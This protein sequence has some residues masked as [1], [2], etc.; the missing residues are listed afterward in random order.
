MIGITTFSDQRFFGIFFAVAAFLVAC[1]SRSASAGS[2][3]ATT[4]PT[5]IRALIADIGE[6]QHERAIQRI[7]RVGQMTVGNP[8]IANT[9]RELVKVLAGCR[10]ISSAPY[11]AAILRWERTQWR[12]DAGVYEVVFGP[13]DGDGNPYVQVVDLLDPSALSER[14]KRLEKLARLPGPIKTVPIPLPAPATEQ[15]KRLIEEAPLRDLFGKAVSSGSLDTIAGDIKADA[16]FRLGVSDP[17]FKTY[18][19]DMAGDGLESGN[20]QLQHVL[21][22]SGKI[23]KTECGATERLNY[24]DWS[25]ENPDSALLAKIF[26]FEGKIRGVDFYYLTEDRI[27]QRRDLT[28]KLSNDG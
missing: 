24:C 22:K 7:S 12:C 11:E 6:G 3:L 1:S 16:T 26:V 4:T 28:E 17:I 18:I 20:N 8:V 2:D 25:F 23:T 9:G 15:A 27:L 5:S 10:L 14:R 21:Q 19:V 13:E